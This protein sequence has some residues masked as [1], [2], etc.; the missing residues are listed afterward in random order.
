MSENRKNHWSQA[1]VAAMVFLIFY[2]LSLGPVVWLGSRGYIHQQLRHPIAMFYGP[3]SG[4]QT[5]SN[6]IKDGMSEY[7]KLWRADFPPP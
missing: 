2:P 3:L 6:T 4:V 5:H 1:L 7:L